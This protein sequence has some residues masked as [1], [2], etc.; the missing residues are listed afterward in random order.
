MREKSFFWKRSE[1]GISSLSS[2]QRGNNCRESFTNWPLNLLKR[3]RNR[4]TERGERDWKWEWWE[5][6]EREVYSQRLS[7]CYCTSECVWA[8]IHV[9]TWSLWVG[10][11]VVWLSWMC[12]WSV[13]VLVCKCLSVYI[14]GVSVWKSVHIDILVLICRLCMWLQLVCVYV[15]AYLCVRVCAF[16]C[17]WSAGFTN[18]SWWFINGNNN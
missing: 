13:C 15:C 4:A 14:S 6:R 1:R 18:T 17:V 16:V 8:C 3:Q 11:C 5:G 10:T 2:S 12:V 9:H 7:V